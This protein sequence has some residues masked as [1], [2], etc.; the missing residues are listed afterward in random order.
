MLHERVMKIML[1]KVSNTHWM[2]NIDHG[3]DNNVADGLNNNSSRFPWRW[4]SI[5]MWTSDS[6]GQTN[7]C[8]GVCS[9]DQ[10]RVRQRYEYRWF[11]FD[12]RI[13]HTQIKVLDKIIN[14]QMITG[15]NWRRYHLSS[16]HTQD[17]PLEWAMW[18]KLLSSNSPSC[19]LA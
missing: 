1:M 14:P 19:C 9:R 8:N 16:I 5:I 12:S 6:I 11:W 2:F 13:A 15:I 4:N 3:E 18:V 17:I 7:R 10:P